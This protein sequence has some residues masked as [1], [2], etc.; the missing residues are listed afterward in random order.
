M[1]NIIVI[2]K[3]EEEETLSLIDIC[4]E[5]RENFSIIAASNEEEAGRLLETNEFD[6]LICDLASRPETSITG[7]QQ[8]TYKYA[9][10]PCIAIIDPRTHETEELMQ[11]GVSSCLESPIKN[12]TLFR[13]V[14]ELLDISTSGTLKGLPIHSLLQMIEGEGKTCTLKVLGEANTGDKQGYIYTEKGAV[15]AAKTET[16]TGEEAVY[17]IIGWE[18]A[19]AEIKFYNSI[20]DHEIDKTL[21]SLLMEGFRLKDEQKDQQTDQQPQAKPSRDLKHFATA[22]KGLLLENGLKIKMELIKDNAP[23]HAQVVGSVPE[24]YLIVTKPEDFDHFR[25]QSQVMDR[26]VVKYLKMGRVC[27]FKTDLLKSLHDPADLLFLEYPRVIHYHE[28]RRAKR[29]TTFIPCTVQLVSELQFSGVLLDISNKGC[30][31]Q[32][33]A[34]RNKELPELDIGSQLIINGLFPGIQEVQELNG[35]VKNTKKNQ[36]ELRIGVELIDLPESIQNIIARYLDTLN[37]I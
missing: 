33:K 7:L 13:W 26:I 12:D 4:N 35:I 5:W 21:M 6:L 20:R 32:I 3:G 9:Y 28:L 29:A 14:H 36:T 30:L 16:L 15:V 18:N 11:T 34:S 31:C 19:T 10:V 27:M 37:D 24:K 17:A 22:G 8:L 23:L 25:Q 1:R 2:T